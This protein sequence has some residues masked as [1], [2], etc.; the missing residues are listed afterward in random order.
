MSAKQKTK[1]EL[2]N[3]VKKLQKIIAGLK[4]SSPSKSNSSKKSSA[5]SFKNTN[6]TS[7][8]NN[9]NNI[10]IMMDKSGKILDI[11]KT[12]KGI[13]KSD[14]IGANGFAFVEGESLRLI[15]D[16]ISRA[17]KTRKSV[18]YVNERLNEL[19]KMVYYN[20]TAI[21][22]IE[23]KKVI[24]VLIEVVDVTSEIEVHNELVKSE[25]QF[26]KLVQNASDAVYRYSIYPT[27]KLEYMSPSIE[28][29]SG[30]S[31]DDFYKDNDLAFKMV[32]KDDVH[33]LIDLQ[34]LYLV[35]KITDEDIS[36]PRVLRWVKKDGSIIWVET[37]NTHIY[38][39]SGKLIAVDGISRNVT[40]RQQHEINALLARHAELV[41]G[42]IFQYQVSPKEG[43]V[44][45]PFASSKITEIFEVTPEDVRKSSKPAFDRVHPDDKD[46]IVRLIRES[47]KTLKD[48]DYE[49]RVILPKRGLRWLS[50]HAKP[51]KLEDGSFLW[52]GYYYDITD[53]KRA[54]EQIN[55]S[56]KEK[57]VL[58]Q[59]VH[60]RVKNNLQVISSI[61]NLQSS[62]VKD[63]GT[64]NVLRDSQNRIK[65]M[66]FIHESLYRT[67]NFSSI[68]FSDY[69][70]NLINNLVQS[71]AKA[72]QK[73]NLKL[74]LAPIHL[75]LDN[76]IPCGLIINEIVSNSLKYAFNQDAKN[77]TISLG[78]KKRG[79]D[80]K[81][82]VADNGSGLP[83]NV[84][85]R[86]TESLGL[87]LVV[88]LV[89]Q[90]G[91]TIE[92]NNK[93]G[94]VYTIRFSEK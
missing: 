40:E 71:Y 83:K 6:L 26:K 59:E 39:T 55:Q 33:I 35:G 8:L 50:G 29:I 60:H 87:Q 94:A 61:L 31:A 49:F 30:Y 42:M 10:V 72:N 45:F 76:A 25:Q 22:I 65:S 68:N 91:G 89:G 53:R 28:K 46:D 18:K 11:N 47:M 92:L 67:H 14:V 70:I 78:M 52:H 21:P 16:A 36:K 15:K 44:F 27:R 32:H 20:S 58:L 3:E 51:E 43:R 48:V 79:N 19:G 63:K 88:T 75:S 90:L 54:I 77:A 37:M 93:K 41:P 66:S 74:D 13:K 24:A 17:Y 85:F 2:E 23:N 34:K 62:F 4:K 86:N 80:V 1:T 73:I 81:L 5:P 56:L 84:D 57:E 9:L 12:E 82:V 69:V 38:D 7:L 64:L